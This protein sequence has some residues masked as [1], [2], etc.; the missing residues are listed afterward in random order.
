MME[1]LPDSRHDKRTKG[2][3]GCLNSVLIGNLYND[4]RASTER[5]ALSAEPL[6]TTDS[7]GLFQALIP[8]VSA[9]A[10]LCGELFA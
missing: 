1:R 4:R 3:E 8:S 9:D 5:D 2:Q 10:S 7:S 6:R